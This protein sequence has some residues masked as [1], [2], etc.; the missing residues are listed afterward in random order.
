VIDQLACPSL[1][2][3]GAMC[4]ADAGKANPD[5]HQAAAFPLPPVSRFRHAHRCKAPR[6]PPSRVPPL[7]GVLPASSVRCSQ[8]KQ[9]CLTF[10]L[11]AYTPIFATSRHMVR[12]SVR[13]GFVPTPHSVHTGRI[14]SSLNPGLDRDGQGGTGRMGGGRRA[15]RGGLLPTN[16][17]VSWCVL[18]LLVLCAEW[19]TPTTGR[20]SS[21]ASTGCC[22]SR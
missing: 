14:C 8:Q 2:V 12:H 9:P 18:P 4:A 16:W 17:H 1:A 6:P 20:A 15:D 22:S 3:R 11:L 19:N 21:A 13:L 5:L 10:G 7:P